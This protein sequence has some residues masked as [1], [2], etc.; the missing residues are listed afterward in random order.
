M[1]SKKKEI[2]N[3]KE[4]SNQSHND[5]DDEINGQENSK[6]TKYFN[7]EMEKQIQ[8]N[9]PKIIKTQK[10]PVAKSEEEVFNI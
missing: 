9:N 8:D 1:E 5:D 6:G 7:G 10:P 4:I 3:P 2:N